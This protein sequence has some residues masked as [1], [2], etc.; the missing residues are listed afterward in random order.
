[1]ALRGPEIPTN[2]ERSA[3]QLTTCGNWVVRNDLYPAGKTTIASIV[4]KGWIEQRVGPSG[5]RQ[6]CVTQTG[7]AAL[8]AKIP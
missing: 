8:V 6:F 1:M 2:R 3:L 7:R 5:A 4:R